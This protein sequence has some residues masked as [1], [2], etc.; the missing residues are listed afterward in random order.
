MARVSDIAGSTDPAYRH[1]SISPSDSVAVD[2]R[3]RAL[4]VMTDGNVVI[5]DEAGTTITYA[6]FAGDIMPIRPAYVMAATTATVVG[7]I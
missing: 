1:V 5:K 2:S 6:Q 4:R 7:W 3:I